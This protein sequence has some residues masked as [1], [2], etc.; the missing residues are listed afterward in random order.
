MN[1]R[2]LE[3]DFRSFA[4][5]PTSAVE[6]ALMVSRIV[7]PDT[8]SA[9]CRDELRRLAAHAGP[10]ATPTALVES[11]RAAGFAGA[12]QYYDTNN[13]ALEFV[14][15]EQRGIPITLAMV[16]VGTGECLDM[17]ATGINFPGHFMAQ[18]N[19]QLFDP[20][21]MQRIDAAG[22][23]DW[24]MK[25]N[26]SANTAFQSATPADVV[27][28]MLNNLRM[29]AM[30]RG[31]HA[32]ALELTDYQLIVAPDHFSTRI[33]RVDLWMAL[34]AN[35]MARQELAVAISMAPS[36]T[37]RD[38]LEEKFQAIAAARPTLH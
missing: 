34:G 12:E 15:R 19:E 30:S 21:V 32:G 37:L 1:K 11:L 27:M 18:L 7:R 8:N 5:D 10:A 33:E 14:L 28:R 31:D 9:W 20:F 6:G 26:V 13:S 3:D 38:Q 25:S 36:G 2:T 22:R 4:A 29:L 16:I 24:L 17:T 23:D 35:D